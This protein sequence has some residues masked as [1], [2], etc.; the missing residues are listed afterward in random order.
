MSGLG[1]KRSAAEVRGFWEKY[2]NDALFPGWVDGRQG[3]KLVTD[4]RRPLV[5]VSDNRW[6][7]DCP[8]CGGGIAVWSDHKEACCL[9]CGR[10]YRPQFPSKAEAERVKEI[11]RLRPFVNRHWRRQ[12]GETVEQLIAENIE[13]GVQAPGGD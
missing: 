1:V 10:I 4:K 13:M 3:R 11:L 7:A 8:N 9:D 5:Y 12:E 6:V 2:A